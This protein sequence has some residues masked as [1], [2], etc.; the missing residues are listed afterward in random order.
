MGRAAMVVV[1]GLEAAAGARAREAL[2]LQLLRHPRQRQALAGHGH[3]RS[4][5][6]SVASVGIYAGSTTPLL[7][8]TFRV[9]IAVTG[10]CIR[11]TK[12]Q[13]ASSTP[14]ERT[15]PVGGF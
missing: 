11:E 12:Q 4:W 2:L 5:G 8:A 6:S 14:A 9:L 7:S 10:K 13:Q 3:Q 1:E 15:T